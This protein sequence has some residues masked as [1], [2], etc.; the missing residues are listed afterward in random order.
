MLERARDLSP[1]GRD[2]INHLLGKWSIRVY[3][4]ILDLLEA[5]TWHSDAVVDFVLREER[6]L[7][8]IETMIPLV[9]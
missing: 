9:S 4:E 5:G 8:R 7:S 3:G 6:Y 1:A 2:G